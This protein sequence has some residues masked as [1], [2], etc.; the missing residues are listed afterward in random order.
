[1]STYHLLWET[2]EAQLLSKLHIAEGATVDCD[3]D[4][5]TTSD[6]LEGTQVNT[7]EL[8]QH[9]LECPNYENM[10]WL[11]GMAGTGK[12]TISRTVAKACHLNRSMVNQNPLQRRNVVLGASF[13]FDKN[14]DDR[15]TTKHLFTTLCRGLTEHM[16]NIKSDVCDVISAHPNIGSESISKQ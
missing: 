12:S 6:C 14:D 2:K 3:D 10:F 1:M 11:S 5:D 16:P 8:I 9:W 15:K 13:L 7:L 4:Q